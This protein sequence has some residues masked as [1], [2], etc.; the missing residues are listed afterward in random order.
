MSRKIYIPLIIAGGLLLV[1][2]GGYT[3]WNAASPERS[4]ASCHEINPSLD[5]WQVS[6]HREINCLECHGTALSN[7]FHSIKEKLG[8]VF[9]HVSDDVTN[10][11]IRLT[12]AQ[13]LETMTRCRDCHREEY[14]KWQS[15]GHSATYADIFLNEEHNSMEQPYWDC[16]RCHG[17]HY[18]GTIYDLM[19][20]VSTE[21]PWTI[22]QE[23]KAGDPTINCMGCHEI[24]SE[25]KPLHIPASLDDP[26]K[27]FYDRKKEQ[28]GAFPKAGLT[29]RADQVFLRADHL[30]LPEIREGDRLLKQSAN[31][32]QR[33]CVQCHAPNFRHAAGTE[34]DKTPSGVHEGLACVACHE[35]HSNDAVSS[36]DRCHPVISNCGLDHKTMNTSYLDP[37]SPNDIHQVKCTDCHDESRLP[38]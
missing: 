4:C 23:G 9:T 16:F 38:R 1:V 17:M 11:E 3:A 13:L 33:L 37:G 28:S 31:P 2:A 21:G 18:E 14:Q 35:T 32:V 8:M 7:G 20:P 10:E 22:I 25:N 34:D 15:G 5:M 27:L 24:H 12:E 6:S 30:P 26:S 36:C 29:I 19:E